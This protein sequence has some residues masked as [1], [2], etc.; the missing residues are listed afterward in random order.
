MHMKVLFTIC[1]C[2]TVWFAVKL[3]ADAAL[4]FGVL[5]I[6]LLI[7]LVRQSRLLYD[8]NLIWNN[9]ILSMS[10]AIIYI[11]GDKGIK[12]ADET[13]VSTFGIL[14]GSKIYK[15]GCDGMYGV[16]LNAIEIDHSRIYL[17]FGDGI[18]TMQA[19]LL[20]GMVDEQTV[21]GV[22]QKLWHETGVVPVIKGW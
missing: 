14:V 19:E 8:A 9:C 11:L 18:N 15:W 17:T 5:N 10:S 21:M 4:I 6:I 22:K 3:M 13:V 1:I 12:D 2:L 20:H 16:R 7:L